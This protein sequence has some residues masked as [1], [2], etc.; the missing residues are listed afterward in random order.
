MKIKNSFAIII[1]VIFFCAAGERL[2]AQTV[3]LKPGQEVKFGLKTK[4]EKMVSLSL[5]KGDFAEISW[6]DSL[7]R[8][9]KFTILSPGGKDILAEA[10]SSDT[11][12]FVAQ[13]DG[14]YRLTLVFEDSDKTEQ[15]EVRLAYTNV[16]K[17]P[18]GA[19][20]VRQR[21]A[22][23]YDVKV[24]NVSTEEDY[25]SFLLIEKGGKL[26]EFLKGD[27]VVGGGFNFA[28]DP[29]LWDYPAGK[30]SAT[31]FRTTADKTGEGT[32]DIA[33]QY[34]TGGA[35][36]C[37]NMYFY[38]LG[39]EAV[40]KVPTI[41]GYDSDII[42]TGRRPQGSLI[43]RTGDSNFAYW[44]TSFAG[45]P[46]PSVILTF[47]DG[48]FRADPKLM[49]KNPPGPAVLKAKAAKVKKNLDLRA[50]TGDEA[51]S[52]DFG[53]AFWG[54][55]LDLLYAGNEAAAWTYFDLVWDARKP[56]KEKFR[57]DFLA[58]L[59]KSKFW[60]QLQEK[61]SGLAAQ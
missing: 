25:G 56:G 60:Q 50:Y 61:K 14:E 32:P 58:Q 51:N 45:S 23:G 24:Y 6:R 17:L 19:K 37:F 44:L 29:N 28:D 2:A 21:K 30:K 59:G 33:V 43:L 20:L 18:Q 10:A 12:A 47:R 49:K 55:M 13:E 52:I 8:Y 36:C 15:G 41:F 11:P 22:N 39:S 53:E 31:L 42:A 54:E 27:S 38:E 46:I 40:K 35:H 57:Q 7:E 48:E 9:P 5:K 1:A 34:Y 16:F 26:K 3:T 4:E